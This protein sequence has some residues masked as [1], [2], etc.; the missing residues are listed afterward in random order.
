MVRRRPK[1]VV[2][3]MRPVPVGYGSHQARCPRCDAF[4]AEVV[5]VIAL[6]LVFRCASCGTRFFQVATSA[7]RLQ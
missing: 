3:P 7:Y 5:G 2:L 4:G 1:P 6:R